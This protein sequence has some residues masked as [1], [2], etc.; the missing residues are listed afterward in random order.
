MARILGYRDTPRRRA[1]ITGMGVIAPN[2]QDL[3]TFWKTIRQGIS[4]AGPLTRFDTT[5]LPSKIAAEVSDFDCAK[6]VGQK[7]AGRYDLTI[8][9]GVAAAIQATRDARLDLA[10]I[11]PDR[12]G[13]IE[14][15]TLS[16]AEACFRGQKDYEARGYRRLSPFYLINAYSGGGSGEI[17]IELGVKGPSATYSAGSA[18]SNDAIGLGMRMIRNDEI[19]VAVVVGAEAPILPPLYGGFC[20]GGVMSSRNNEP[21]RAMRP[22]SSDSDGFVLGEGAGCLVLEEHSFALAR[23]ARIYAELAGQGRICEAYH[24]VAPE[25]KGAGV[26][27]AMEE[28]LRDAGMAA[29]EIDYIN[30][31]G[32]A[33][34]ANDMAEI[35][36]VKHLF[37]K[38]APRVAISSTKPVTGHLLA[39]AGAIEAVACCLAVHHGEIPPTINFSGPMNG[40]ELDFVP[41]RY[42]SY[43]IR[44]A[45]SINSGFGGKNSCLIVR[46]L[47]ALT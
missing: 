9:F 5:Q 2:G 15:S 7:K 30:A 29:N 46:R 14:A 42:R 35:A 22:F 36:A 10:R 24:S 47:P 38:L 3:E 33:T 31:H 25:P 27:R 37:G 32:T 6:Y 11:N 13:V 16:N 39:A 19:D 21:G 23:Q 12:V 17:S 8:Q 40:G 34:V 4:A 18:S 44:S 20:R 43:P 41:N 45:I 26:V 1:V 28:A